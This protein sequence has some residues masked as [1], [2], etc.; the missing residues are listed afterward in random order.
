MRRAFSTAMILVADQNRTTAELLVR[1][2]RADGLEADAASSASGVLRRVEAGGVSAL[3]LDPGLPGAAYAALHRI[4][5]QG[6]TRTLPV[7][8]FGASDRPQD[9]EAAVAAGAS[10]F[11][12]KGRVTPTQLVDRIRT[13]LS[14]G[15]S[16]EA[17][18]PAAKSTEHGAYYL[19]VRPDGDA[20]RL[21][22][23]RGVPSG[24]RC[25]DCK[26]ALALYLQR[27]FS[28]WGRWLFGTFGCLVCARKRTNVVPTAETP[29][30]KTEPQAAQGGSR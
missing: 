9:A 6:E 4:R 26:G 29:F 3:V 30:G 1:R 22:A 2:L 16:A 8:V 15:S 25:P 12:V 20:A 14:S 23:D 28:R 24:M 21:A 11:L 27:D 5:T 17:V 13:L 19:F 10:A 7:I 18:T